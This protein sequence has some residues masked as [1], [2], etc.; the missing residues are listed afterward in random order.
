MKDQYI[1]TS[2]GYMIKNG[3]EEKCDFRFSVGDVID[4]KYD[5]YYNLLEL[6]KDNGRKITMKINRK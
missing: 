1:V 6:K 3:R 4:L 2:E 5:L